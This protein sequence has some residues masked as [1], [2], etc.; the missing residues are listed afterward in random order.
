MLNFFDGIA[1]GIEQELYRLDLVEKHLRDVIRFALDDMV[2]CEAMVKGVKECVDDIDVHYTSL[3]AL[4]R[5]WN[6]T[7]H[8]RGFSSSR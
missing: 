3:G 4:L 8:K 5:H 6:I 2:S 7:E 1:I